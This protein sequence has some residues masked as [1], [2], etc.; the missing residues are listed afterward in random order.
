MQDITES[1]F[2]ADVAINYILLL[3][4]VWSIVF[5]KKKNLATP[6]KMVMAIFNYMDMKKIGVREQLFLI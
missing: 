1:I 2:L 5:P 3:G 6:K 4:V